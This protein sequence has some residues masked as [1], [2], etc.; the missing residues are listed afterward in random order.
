M[1]DIVLLKCL[2]RNG[3]IQFYE[4]D[5]TLSCTN[6]KTSETVALGEWNGF[7]QHSPATGQEEEF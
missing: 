5:G 1:I 2:A 4:D 3:T 7:N 6:L